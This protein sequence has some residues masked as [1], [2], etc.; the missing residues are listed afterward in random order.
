MSFVI[1]S[2]DVHLRDSTFTDSAATISE[3]CGAFNESSIG[4]RASFAPETL[5]NAP[6]LTDTP[7]SIASTRPARVG[8]VK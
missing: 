5:P 3:A 6:I 1:Q 8:M 7:I 2:I 4:G